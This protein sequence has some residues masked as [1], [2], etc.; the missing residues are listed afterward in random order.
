MRT[1]YSPDDY[2]KLVM[3]NNEQCADWLDY[4]TGNKTGQLDPWVRSRD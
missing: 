1:A 2:K 4:R 3:P